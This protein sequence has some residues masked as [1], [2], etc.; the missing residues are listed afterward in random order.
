KWEVPLLR[1]GRE[2]ASSQRFA[3]TRTQGRGRWSGPS[4]NPARCRPRRPSLSARFPS[5]IRYATHSSLADTGVMS[6]SCQTYFNARV[7]Q[8]RLTLELRASVLRSDAPTALQQCGEML[9]EQKAVVA[10]LEG[11]AAA[12]LST[13][14]R[15]CKSEEQ[16]LWHLLSLGTQ[17]RV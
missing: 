2:G 5:Q 15:L 12:L 9:E 3:S 8:H 4:V 17:R 11:G 10:S 7:T 14:L 6:S 13:R 16:V 1:S